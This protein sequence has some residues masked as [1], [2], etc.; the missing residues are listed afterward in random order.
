MEPKTCRQLTCSS[1]KEHNL[2]LSNHL[3][4]TKRLRSVKSWSTWAATAGLIP[5]PGVDLSVI[6]G[7]QVKMI[8]DLC[9]VYEIPYKKEAVQSIVGGLAGSTLTVLAS[10]YLSARLFRFIPYAGPILSIVIQPGLAF[11]S[12][13]VLGH[14]FIRQFE[15]GQSLVGLTAET[16]SSTYREQLAKTKSW[17][18]KADQESVVEVLD[19][20]RHPVQS[21]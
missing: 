4:S 2:F 3:L 15:S 21:S 6:G 7:L 14:I 11:A 17:F 18:K 1:M 10:G 20:E 8:Y 9:Q 12:T 19:P 13:F 16:V 5:V